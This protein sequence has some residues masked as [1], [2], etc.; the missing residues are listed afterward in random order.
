MPGAALPTTAAAAAAAAVSACRAVGAATGAA[1][2][3][4]HN[5]AAAKSRSGAWPDVE[6]RARGMEGHSVPLLFR[7]PL[8]TRLWH[9]EH[10]VCCCW[11]GV[12]VGS[13]TPGV[14]ETR[15]ARTLEQQLLVLLLL[16][17]RLLALPLTRMIPLR[18]LPLLKILKWPEGTGVL[19][20]SVSVLV[21]RFVQSPDASRLEGS[22]RVWGQWLRGRGKW[23][24]EKEGGCLER[25]TGWGRSSLHRSQGSRADHP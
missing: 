4:A 3:A 21:W 23:E 20:Q 18:V 2:V 6:A 14:L 7:L 25:Q 10:H 9:D 22:W 8:H 19:L 11:T 17:Q 1:A 24:G 13:C 12:A 16:E 15:G 5:G